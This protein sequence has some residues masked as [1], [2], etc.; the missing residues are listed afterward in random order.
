MED[1]L[2]SIKQLKKDKQLIGLIN[3]KMEEFKKIKHLSKEI[4]FKE[5]CF[6]VLTANC[7]AEKCLEVHDNI[8]DGFISY[9]EEKLAKKLKDFGY[10]FPNTRASYIVK[11][12]SYIDQVNQL[13]KKGGNELELRKWVVNNILGLGYK[14]GSHF[15]RN[16]GFLNYA[17]VDFH[18][19]DLLVEYGLIEKPK[20]MTK[21]K[22]LEIEKILIKIA[23]NADLNLANLDLFLWYMKTGKILK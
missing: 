23:Q 17:I 22:Y 15:L 9:S 16:I 4:I 6:C 1:I 7:S 12:R 20:A 11:N 13:A 19:V 8:G 5:L 21:M 3:K 14:E 10:R 2:S 18:I